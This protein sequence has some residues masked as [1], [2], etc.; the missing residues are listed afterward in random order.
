M[1]NNTWNKIVIVGY[2]GVAV[3]ALIWAVAQVIEAR[4]D[5]VFIVPMKLPERS[6]VNGSETTQGIAT[7]KA[8][9]PAQG[10]SGGV[11]AAD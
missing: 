10:V 4:K 1:E 3:A 6:Q 2:C 7:Q 11:P 8:D 9:Q 5:K